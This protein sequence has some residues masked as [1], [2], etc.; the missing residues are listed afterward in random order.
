MRRYRG[1]G[2]ATSVLIVIRRTFDRHAHLP[3]ASG[4]VVADRD[5]VLDRL[6]TQPMDHERIAGITHA[7]CLN[8]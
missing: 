5:A 3:V 6:R 4:D 7:R 1:L 2:D 8:W